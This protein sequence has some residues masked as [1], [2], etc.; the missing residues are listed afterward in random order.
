MKN[1]GLVHLYYGTGKGKTTASLGLALRAWGWRKKIL[2]FQFLKKK[3][4]PSGE[5]EAVKK[6]D[7]NFKIVRFPQEHPLFNK[8]VDRV[9]LK[10]K[11]ARSLI[12]VRKN[13]KERKYDL[14]I[15]DEVLNL[16]KE[17]FVSERKIIALLKEK[18]PSTEII[19]TGRYLSPKLA[20]F[21]DY[22]SE[23]KEIK[24]P[25]QKGIKARRGIEY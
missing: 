5:I 13:I 7:E 15:L 16:I 12:Q 22:I 20:E 6:L 24:H 3:N 19:L 10:K 1:I 17:G 23:I 21:A 25:F 18:N 4:F 2:V 8:N 14:I 9:K 11:I